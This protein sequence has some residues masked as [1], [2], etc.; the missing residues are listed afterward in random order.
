MFGD[1]EDDIEVLLE[2]E[3]ED[4][5]EIREKEDEKPKSPEEDQEESEDNFD[6]NSDD[7]DEKQKYGKRAEKRIRNLVQK[8]RELENVLREKIWKKKPLR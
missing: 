1:E 2:D 4:K 7:L 8:R 5:E 3:D 6:E